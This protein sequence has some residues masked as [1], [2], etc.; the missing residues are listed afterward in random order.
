MMDEV[1]DKHFGEIERALCL[2]ENCIESGGDFKN[3]LI[4]VRDI[5]H[6]AQCELHASTVAK[7]IDSKIAL[8]DD[9]RNRT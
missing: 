1:H 8:S 9:G 5:I 4:E 2:A 7:L 6:T 3:T